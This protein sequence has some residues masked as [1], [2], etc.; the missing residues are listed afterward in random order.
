MKNYRI[1]IKKNNN[2]CLTAL[3]LQIALKI[4]FNNDIC[5]SANFINVINL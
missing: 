4:L 3:I 5:N 2:N 1:L